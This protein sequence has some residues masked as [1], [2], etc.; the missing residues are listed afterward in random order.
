MS[1]CINPIVTSLSTRGNIRKEKPI[2]WA[3]TRFVP[4]A[5]TSRSQ[6][7]IYY[8]Y[9][10]FN[11]YPRLGTF[12]G[13]SPLASG[14]CLRGAKKKPLMTGQAGARLYD[15]DIAKVNIN[16][17]CLVYH[18]Y[19]FRIGIIG[20]DDTSVREPIKTNGRAESKQTP[21]HR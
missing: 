1:Y 12:V 8:F 19:L 4:E 15:L 18:T 14:A 21:F 9:E 16:E 13:Q 7:R 10:T 5:I 20:E 2:Q 3:S 17:K 11:K 6:V